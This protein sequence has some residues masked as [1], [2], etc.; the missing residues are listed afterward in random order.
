MTDVI[1]LLPE[2]KKIE[3]TYTVF[4]KTRRLCDV[5]NVCSVHSKFFL[6]ALV[7]LGK[8]PDDNYKYVPREIF[9]IGEV[10][11]D[12]PRVEITIKEI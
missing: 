2:L 12:N 6:D 4:P 3:L 1:E 9:Q 8:I 5:S 11:P 10:D 7:E